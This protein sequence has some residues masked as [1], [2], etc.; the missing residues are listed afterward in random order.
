M[1]T[2]PDLSGGFLEV[3]YGNG[4]DE[5]H[6]QRIH[7]QP[8]DIGPLTFTAVQPIAPGDVPGLVQQIEP[9]LLS[10]MPVAYSI[11]S[12]DLY[13]IEGGVPTFITTIPPHSATPIGTDALPVLSKASQY[14]FNFR[15]L[16]NHS[17]KLI[18]LGCHNT[19]AVRQVD[20]SDAFYTPFKS[21][22]V[23]NLPPGNVLNGTRV[24]GHDG[25]SLKVIRSL[26]STLNRRLRR[27]YRLA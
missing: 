1:A 4:V 11:A 2:L 15:T 10:F 21:A 19:P 24:V 16:G 12:Y 22:F 23:S 5:V 6:T 20:F 3:H 9:V 17:A 25:Q 13:A 7:V 26:T 8:F 14:T 18:F 27:H